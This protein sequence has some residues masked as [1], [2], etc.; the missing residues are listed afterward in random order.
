DGAQG[1]AIECIPDGPQHFM[2]VCDAV[3]AAPPRCVPGNA[4][5]L[6]DHQVERLLLAIPLNGL[7]DGAALAATAH[8]LEFANFFRRS[9]ARK[10][11]SKPKDL[12]P[13]RGQSGQVALR[14]ALSATRQG[15]M[16]VTPVQHQKT[17]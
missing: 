16:R 8:D 13:T 3:G 14:D 15:I 11:M 17:H 10:I 4:V 12:V 6:V 9:T 7:A 5:V 1:P 2:D